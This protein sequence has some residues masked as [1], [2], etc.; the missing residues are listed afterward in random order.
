M[1]GGQDFFFFLNARKKFTCSH[2][3]YGNSISLSSDI[4]TNIGISLDLNLAS[5][6]KKC[7]G[8]KQQR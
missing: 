3:S 7:G 2:V 8:A 6:L 5:I 1:V 4:R